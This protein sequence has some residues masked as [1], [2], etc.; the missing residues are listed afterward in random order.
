MT[1]M[2]QMPNELNPE[3]LYFLGVIVGDGSLPIKHNGDKKRSF[4]ITIEKANEKFIVSVLKPLAERLFG[5]KWSIT[6]RLREGRKQ[7]WCLYLYSKAVYRFL[8]DRFGLP[9]GE[10]SRKIR[11]PL[12]IRNLSSQQ[13]LPFLAGVMDTD[14]GVQGNSF[15][16][17][18]S[19]KM[20][21]VD[22]RNAL[23]EIIGFSPRITRYVQGSFISYQMRLDTA[24]KAKLFNVLETYFPL[25]NH[26]RRLCFQ[27]RGG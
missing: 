11:M 26:K 13:R 24:Q 18:C 12:K 3:L 6:T 23:K 14:W 20:L 19:S 8:V 27:C 17:H 4:V 16:T 7:T 2:V 1:K 15:G 5:V 25:R 21:L 10:K 9:E 22:I